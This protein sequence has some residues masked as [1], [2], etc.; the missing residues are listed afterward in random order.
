MRKRHLIHNKRNGATKMTN[1]KVLREILE[2]IKRIE[3]ALNIEMV[4]PKEYPNLRVDTRAF[5]DL[6]LNSVSKKLTIDEVYIGHIDECHVDSDKFSIT[7]KSGTK[8]VYKLESIIKLGDVGRQSK[9]MVV[10]NMTGNYSTIEIINPFD[11]TYL[12]AT[13]PERLEKEKVCELLNEISL[14]C[15][16][17]ITDEEMGDMRSNLDDTAYFGYIGLELQNALRLAICTTDDNEVSIKL[18]NLLV[19]LSDND[20]DLYQ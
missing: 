13:E 17:H 14:N 4:E 9:F 1:E 15:T 7:L 11:V 8:L 3:K 16:D 18:S 6:V 12:F 2:G 10:E 19:R 20:S 5:K